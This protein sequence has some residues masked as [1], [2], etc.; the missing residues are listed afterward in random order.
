[1]V[2]CLLCKIYKESLEELIHFIDWLSIK[3][4]QVWEQLLCEYCVEHKKGG[5]DKNGRKR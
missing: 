5:K 4:P 3:Y 2:K 1:M